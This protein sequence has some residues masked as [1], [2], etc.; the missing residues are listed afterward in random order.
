MT[1]GDHRDFLND[2]VA[3]AEI[4]ADLVAS[5]PLDAI[6]ADTKTRLALERALEIMGE[7]ASRIPQPVRD[8]YPDLPWAQMTALR[9]RLVHGYFGID[10][11]ILYRIA[12]EVIPAT[13]PRLS[14]I[15]RLEGA[16]R[17]PTEDT[18]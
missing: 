14:E 2:I 5:A 6:V 13:L 9:H 1:A 8:R 16:D 11:E 3:H 7:A 12:R 10:H 4:A 17:P 18:P 15:V